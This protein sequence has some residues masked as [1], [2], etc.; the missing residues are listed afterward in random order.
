MVESSARYK[1]MPCSVNRGT[2]L[3]TGTVK[4]TGVILNKAKDLEKTFY[5]LVAWGHGSSH[6]K[7]N[8]HFIVT[9]P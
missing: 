4:V 6:T 5:T 7:P 1:G 9:L 3:A 2:V 8:P